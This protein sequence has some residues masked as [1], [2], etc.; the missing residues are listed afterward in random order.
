MYPAENIQLKGNCA[1]VIGFQP[2][3]HN[4]DLRSLS[5]NWTQLWTEEVKVQRLNKPNYSVEN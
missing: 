2:H 3:K 4:F 5:T 1:D